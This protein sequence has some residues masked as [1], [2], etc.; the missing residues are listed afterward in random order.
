MIPYILALA[1]VCFTPQRGVNN[2]T[3][4]FS[5]TPFT[6]YTFNGPM[7]VIKTPEGTVNYHVPEGTACIV[8]ENKNNDQQESEHADGQ[9]GSL[10]SNPNFA[11]GG[12]GRG[13]GSVPDFRT[14][15]H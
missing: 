10:R 3:T 1:F 7:A 8:T 11:T 15:A 9:H 14:S 13:R 2:S 5:V 12:H 6:S 4:E